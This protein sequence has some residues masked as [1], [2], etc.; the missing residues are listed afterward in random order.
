MV[1]WANDAGNHPAS[2]TQMSAGYN[3]ACGLVRGGSVT[4]WGPGFGH[5]QFPSPK[6]TFTAVSA[7][8]T[9]ACGLRP[10]AGVGCWGQDGVL[11]VKYPLGTPLG[12]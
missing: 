7:G 11:N 8:L 2:F 10:D 5:S 12:S 1:C 3:F 4:C 6:G 9:L